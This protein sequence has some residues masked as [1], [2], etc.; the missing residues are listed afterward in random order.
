MFFYALAILRPNR[1][2]EIFDKNKSKHFLTTA[3]SFLFQKMLTSTL[4]ESRLC[5]DKLDLS[6]LQLNDTDMTDV[7]KRVIRLK[8]CRVLLLNDNHISERGASILASGLETDDY[9]FELNLWNNPLGDAGVH[10]LASVLTHKNST[11]RSLALG[12]NGIQD[13]GATDLAEMLKENRT[14]IRLWLFH[15]NIGDR[16]MMNLTDTLEKHNNHLQ[17]LDLRLNKLV[18]DASIDSLT[19]MLEKNKGLTKFWMEY[20]SLTPPMKKKLRELARKKNNFEIGA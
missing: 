2:W 18:T 11:L 12:D 15:N 8:L 20:C 17:W 14:L 3:D 16:G 1:I 10:H 13:E 19:N 4:I 7:V 5:G 6:F 9:L